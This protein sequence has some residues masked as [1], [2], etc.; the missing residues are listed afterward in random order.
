MNDQFARQAQDMFAAAKEARIPENVKAFAEE[1]VAKTRDA[2]A[3]INAATQDNVKAVEEI[4]LAAGVP[5]GD[6]ASKI[7]ALPLRLGE[8]FRLRVFS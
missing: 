7:E 8:V 1:S 2:Y 6:Q 3:K 5:R 4:V